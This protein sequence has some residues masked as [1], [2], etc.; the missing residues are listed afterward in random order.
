MGVLRPLFRGLTGVAL[1]SAMTLPVLAQDAANDAPVMNASVSTTTMTKPQVV[2]AS[3]ETM[4]DARILAAAASRNKVA[5]VVWGGTKEL[6]F[7][8]YKAAQDMVNEGIPT[9]L[10]VA[11]DHN[12][13]P[14]DAIFQIYAKSAP[15]GEDSHIGTDHV[16]LVREAMYKHAK[17]AYSTNYSTKIAE[18]DIR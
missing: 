1:A 8:A 11:P 5:I 6:Q 3:G 15:Q 10:V 17:Y 14:Q 13:T 18:L 16:G 4:N 2:N 12:T 7:E 9:A